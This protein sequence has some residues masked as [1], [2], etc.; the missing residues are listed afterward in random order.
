MLEKIKNIYFFNLKNI[1][2]DTKKLLVIFIIPFLIMISLSGLSA[3]KEQKSSFNLAI[4]DKENSFLSRM[5]IKKVTKEKTLFDFIK[6]DTM[7]LQHAKKELEEGEL[8][9]ILEIPE[10]FS[11]GLMYMQNYP[12]KII[13]NKNDIVNSYLIENL[14]SSFSEYI[15]SVEVSAASLYEVLIEQGLSVKEAASVNDAASYELISLAIDRKKFF[16]FIENEEIPSISS[17][18]YN[19]VSVE[20]LIIFFVGSLFAIE[21]SEEKNKKLL[22]RI[23]NIGVS[24]QTVV[25]GKL[26]SYL[27]VMVL[28]IVIIFIPVTFFVNNEQ[29]YSINIIVYSMICSYFILAFWRVIEAFVKNKEALMFLGSALTLIFAVLGG[30][31]FPIYLMPYSMRSIAKITPNFWL[32]K[33]M[34]YVINGS[35][36]IDILIPIITIIAISTIMMAIATLKTKNE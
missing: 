33:Y 9:A 26:M 34:M 20:I 6:F 19:V 35:A 15:T 25:C 4:V 28:Q 1:L 12:L 8:T 16:E 27:T 36:L 24:N 23:K 31:F 2:S 30:T 29:L 17:V 3:E 18:L 14:C 32:S 7:N 11:T 21:L 5:L 22:L 13:L 10:N